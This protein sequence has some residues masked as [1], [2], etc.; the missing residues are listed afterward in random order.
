MPR[1]VGTGD[2]LRRIYAERPQY[3][4]QQTFNGRAYK[5]EMDNGSPQS[6][7]EDATNKVTPAGRF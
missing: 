3:R 5:A 6:S 7:I 2:S 1:K 4:E